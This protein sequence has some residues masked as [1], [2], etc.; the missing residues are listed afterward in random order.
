MTEAV[1]YQMI[2]RPTADTAWEPT[3]HILSGTEL[4]VAL[5]KLIRTTTV[6]WLNPK[7][8]PVFMKRLETGET[9]FIAFRLLK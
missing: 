9:V 6:C 7:E 3:E 2:S 5:H 1:R 4:D 8:V